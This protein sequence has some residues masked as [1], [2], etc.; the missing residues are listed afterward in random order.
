MSELAA[1]IGPWPE[2][3]KPRGKPR[4]YGH[5]RRCEC[6]ECR[7]RVFWGRQ[8]RVDQAIAAV[9]PAQLGCRVIMAGGKLVYR[10]VEAEPLRHTEP[11]TC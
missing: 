4:I 5:G 8:L 10:R 9:T 3:P 7:E 6:E 2:K 11:V 1:G